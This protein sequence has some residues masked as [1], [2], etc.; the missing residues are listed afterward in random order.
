MKW[1]RVP[2]SRC[3][4][5]QPTKRAPWSA[6][7]LMVR[8]SFERDDENPGTIGAINT[9]TLRPAS[10]SSRTARRRWSG[11]A[12]PGS[13]VRHASSSTVG[14]LMQTVQ[15]ATFD[16]AA[17]TSR[18]RTTMGPLVTMPTGVQAL[19]KASIDRRVSR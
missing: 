6:M 9:P 12:V 14:T 15:R 17:S 7:A 1:A 19:V 2:S 11:C 3:M 18:S 13:R 4:T 16:N 5:L 10:A 8:S